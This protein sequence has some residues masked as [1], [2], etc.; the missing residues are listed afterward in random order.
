MELTVSGVADMFFW[1]LLGGD[2]ISKCSVESCQ[3]IHYRT[4]PSFLH[5][6]SPELHQPR[7][8]PPELEL[9]S[10]RGHFQDS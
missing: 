5:W 1:D 2:R 6:F 10:V 9:S 4:W 3:N 8:T 7:S